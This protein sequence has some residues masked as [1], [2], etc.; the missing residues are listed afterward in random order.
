MDFDLNEQQKILRD[1]VRKF[2]EK[3]IAPLVDEFDKDRKPITKDIIKKVEP[4][5]YMNALIPEEFGGL[6]LDYISYTIMIEELSRVWGSLRTLV[7]VGSLATYLIATRGTQEQRDKFL[8]D[9]M[10]I[11][12]MG[13]FA[14]TE[15]NV[16]SDASGVETRAVRQGDYY[17][18][19]GTKILITGGSLADVIVLFAT[20]DKTKGS[21][22]ITAFIV[23]KA[24]SKVGTRDIRKMG[25]HS[26]PLSELSFEDCY[27]PAKNRLGEEGEGLKIALN[28]LNRGRVTVAFAAIG[29]AQAALDAATKYAKERNQFGRPIAGFQLVQEMIVDMAMRVDAARLLAYRAAE[30]LDKGVSCVRE[31]SFAKL[32]ATEAMMEVANKAIQVHGGYGYTEEFPVE[33]YYRDG[34][35]LTLAEGT[36]E[37]QKLILGREILGISALT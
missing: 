26:S 17:V 36:S 2:L 37:V 32:F 5:G 34:R 7:S 20:V 6:G 33:R 8:P 29:I 11:N 12:K 9:L 3:E 4:F 14:L 28:G 24:E 22:G 13:C 18:V 19:N 30:M 27:I 16:G 1:S 21:K 15:P 10:A 23:D 35:H 25:M 31:A